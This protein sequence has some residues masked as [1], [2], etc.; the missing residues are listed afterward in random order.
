MLRNGTQISLDC[1]AP[2]G[3]SCTHRSTSKQ[4]RI[5]NKTLK[6]KNACA[7]SQKPRNP[8]GRCTC[9]VE[10]RDLTAGAPCAEGKWEERALRRDPDIPFCEAVLRHLR[11]ARE[12][13]TI[14]HFLPRRLQI[15]AGRDRRG[16]RTPKKPEDAPKSF[17][18]QPYSPSPLLL[19]FK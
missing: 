6:D 1:D 13:T 5:R 14:S 15:A 12:P 16:T 9:A 7:S 4:L 3:S 2:C 19:S 11:T 10:E 8:R 17:G 18:N